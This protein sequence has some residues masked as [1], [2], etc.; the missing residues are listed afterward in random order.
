MRKVLPWLSLLLV[1]ALIIAAEPI[2]LPNL[3]GPATGTSSGGKRTL[4]VSVV[5]GPG[6]QTEDAAHSSGDL[7]SLSLGVRQDT[8]TALAADG[9]YIPLIVDSSGRLHVNV[10]SSALPSGAATAANQVTEQGYVDGL[11]ALIGTT[12]SSLSTIDGRVDGLETLVTSTNTKLDTVNTNLGTIDGR[13]DQ[14]EGYVD[15]LETLIGTTNTSLSTIDGRVDGLEGYLDGVETS[16]TALE[17]YADGLEGYVDGLEGYV[18]GIEGQLTTL[19]GRVDQVE[20]YLDGVETK[21]DTL[22]TQTNQ[23]PQNAEAT[24]S[25][26]ATATGAA[27]SEAA[28]AD[29]VGFILS[30]DDANT[31]N[32]RWRIG[33]TAS[34]TAGH[35]L[36]PGRDTGYIP[37]GVN[38]SIYAVSG[39]QTYQLTWVRR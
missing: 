21:L 14:V 18:D 30:A 22:I 10:G 20:G 8:A 31:A 27:E 1:P 29:A 25:T 12:N 32:I 39:S 5:S 4:D 6:G 23:T 19:D 36:Q 13:V 28:P 15:G 34:A 3:G 7:G 17:G 16:L 24:D 11:E 9:D 33:G 38:L 35:E 37:A 2:Y 26:A